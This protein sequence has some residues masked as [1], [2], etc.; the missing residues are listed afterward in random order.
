[1]QSQPQNRYPE[2]DN[3]D[4]RGRSGQPPSVGDD[5]SWETIRDNKESSWRQQESSR[6]DQF[7][8]S[9]QVQSTFRIQFLY[10]QCFPS[11]YDCLSY[12][13][14]IKKV[15]YRAMH[16]SVPSCLVWVA[17]LAAVFFSTK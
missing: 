8:L 17:F 15:T 2:S 1:M 6:Q 12:K 7:S 9:A 11:L 3:R 10:I 13:N 5:K 16:L 14:V 4:W